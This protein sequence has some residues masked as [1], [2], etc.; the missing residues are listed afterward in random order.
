MTVESRLG[1]VYNQVQW[2]WS[3]RLA[4]LVLLAGGGES[5]SWKMSVCMW[6]WT[7]TRPCPNALQWGGFHHERVFPREKNTF[8]SHMGKHLTFHLYRSHRGPLNFSGGACVLWPLTKGKTRGCWPDPSG[9]P[10]SLPCK[11]QGMTYESYVHG[12]QV[13]VY[14]WVK[15][16]SSKSC[17]FINLH[18]FIYSHREVS[19]R[20]SL[21]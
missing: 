4:S 6:T 13:G 3:Q 9:D 10:P 17:K 16:E 21:V 7:W 14:T 12:G 15:I 1:D 11:S 5:Y 20:N 19:N 18:K 2:G 8:R